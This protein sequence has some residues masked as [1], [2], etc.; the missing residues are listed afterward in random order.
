MKAFRK[1]SDMLRKSPNV[2][3]IGAGMA[4]LRASIVLSRAGV[5]ATLFEARSRIGGRVH[6]Q[7]T[8][9]HLVDMGPNWIHGTKGNPIMELAERTGT[10][11]MGPEE[12]QALFDSDGVR[13]SDEEASDLSAK[14]WGIIVDAFKYSDENSASIDSKMSLYEYF[15]RRLDEERPAL[16]R[17]KRD[18]VLKEAQMWGPFVGDAVGTQ[19][20]KFFFLEECVDGGNVF[21]SGTYEKILAEVGRQMRESGNIDLK[22]DTE[23][24]KI[25]YGLRSSKDDG[26]VEVTTSTGE[27]SSF[28]EVIV[29]CPLGWLKRNHEHM[30]NPRLPIRLQQAISNI[31]YGRLEKLYVTFPEA[32][33]LSAMPLPSTF[34]SSIDT[35][36]SSLN[37]DS[38]PIFTHF[39][40]PN[41]IPH[42]SDTPWNQS[43]V[44]LAHLPDPT[45]HP[46]LLFYI[47][48][49]CATHIVNSISNL[50]PHSEPYDEKLHA[51]AELFFS[52]LPNYNPTSQSCNPTAYLMTQ[53]Q[54][55]P[56][57]GYGSYSNFQVGLEHGD[58]DIEVMRNAGGLS[59][60]GQGVW[61]AG[62]HTAP[63]IALGTTTGA[64][65]SGEA[66]AKRVCRKMGIT[67]DE[68]EPT[69]V[70]G[71][72]EVDLRPKKKNLVKTEMD[73]A[74]AA[75]LAI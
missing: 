29:T 8:G 59:E 20:L 12:R 75:G 34:D 13:R 27:R 23:I 37:T 35:G 38:Y 67:V 56:F 4:G 57:A 62:E 60:E 73:G 68:D 39:H 7:H 61:L 22:L 36:S 1:A 52:R 45:A 71:D 66:V 72:K 15:E 21:V 30:F 65:W 14:V 42:P 5:K 33:W 49:A 24:V 40:D 70:N 43:V 46:T 25:D 41:Y 9:G 31:N 3:V 48:G 63:F 54:A 53:W 64:W 44:S 16:D 74:N 58:Q 50:L 47:Y 2:A 11:F 55:D 17:R 6:Q 32:W 69:V 19:S 26:K 51:F 28:D 18:D 10:S